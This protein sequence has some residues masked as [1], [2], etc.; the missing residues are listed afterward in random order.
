[1]S[2]DKLILDY[3]YDNEKKRADKVYLTQPLTG[4]STVDYTWKQFM[5]EARRMAAH[6]KAQGFEP[7]SRIA[8]ISKNCA[9]FLMA[10]VAI[11]MAG[12]VTVALY[13]TVGHD[14]VE[15]VLE[16]SEAKLAFIGK[17]DTWD[18]MQKGVPSDLPCIAFPL[19]PK[20]DFPTWDAICNETE[21]LEGEP[22]R[23]GEELCMLV[24]TSGST[25]KPKGVMHSFDS[26]SAAGRGIVEELKITAD[27][28]ALSYLPL[29]HVFERAYI[30]TTSL[31]T[32]LHVYFAE[33]LDTFVEDLRR[34]SP[35]I[36]LSV[37][38]LWL[39]FQLGVFHKMPKRRLEILSKIPIL[40]GIVKKK[41]LDGLGL[42]HV[43]IAGSGSAPIPAELIA[44]YR[45]LG[46]NLLEG[47]AMSED[48]AY[49]H[50]SREGLSE[51]GYVGVPYDDVKVDISEEGEILIDSPGKMMGYYKLPE[52]T[53]ESF[54]KEGYFK[55]GDKGTRKPNGLLKITG[56]VK[57]IFK[58]AKGKY[59]APA[60]IENII[61]NDEYVE[62]S[63][64]SGT[65]MPQPYATLVLA[66]EIRAKMKNGVSA[67][68]KDEITARMKS[69][70]AKVN[71]EVEGHE[72]LQFLVV[73][74]DEWSIANEFL[75]PTMKIRRNKIE[76]TYGPRV[77]DW[78]KAKQKVIWA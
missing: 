57:E 61:N 9:H 20:T 49:S 36:F 6:L 25:G 77:E 69:L 44:W 60:P 43:R 59:V 65:G 16:H 12:H 39:K 53:A 14:T 19:A 58:T 56:R 28:R 13:P 35:T 24:Y 1:M 54:T 70:L 21:P 73:V 11:W 32:G 23:K 38:R 74:E 4:G 66:E 33:S 2:A 52:L 15:Y 71:N 72:K 64:V 63:C 26:V 8:I 27:D 46:L 75:T 18:D 62:L 48:F 50:L 37:P 47:Y 78:Y 7:G 40:G 5:D 29:A 22:A 30:S 67:A 45:G 42:G 31:M 41:V 10:E 55:T 68:L 76:D 51:P 17:L 34:A 3:I